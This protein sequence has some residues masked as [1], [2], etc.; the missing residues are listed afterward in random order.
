MPYLVKN[1]ILTLFCQ[2]IEEPR[3]MKNQLLFLPVAWASMTLICSGQLGVTP[4]EQWQFEVSSALATIR[5]EKFE[6]AYPEELIYGARSAVES[7]TFT[8][9]SVICAIRLWIVLADDQLLIA[10]FKQENRAVRSIIAALFICPKTDIAN[11]DLAMLER[12]AKRYSAKEALEREQ[13]LQYVMSNRGTIASAIFESLAKIA[14]PNR[15]LGFKTA[16][17]VGKK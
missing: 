10:W 16:K 1:R 11:F 17:E 14:K 7:G 13:E 15:I 8:S 2:K 6:A 4:P 3:G 9:D 12:H 5:K